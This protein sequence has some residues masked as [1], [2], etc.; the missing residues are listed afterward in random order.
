MSRILSQTAQHVD[1]QI[2]FLS[3]VQLDTGVETVDHDIPS[4]FISCTHSFQPLSLNYCLLS[5]CLS[6]FF[7]FPSEMVRSRVRMKLVY[8]C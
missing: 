7:F 4:C 2:N 3:C 8:P 1:T 5:F 6:F